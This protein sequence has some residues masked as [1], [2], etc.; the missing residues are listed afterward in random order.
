MSERKMLKPVKLEYK[1]PSGDFWDI[2]SKE[3]LSGKWQHYCEIYDELLAAFR[4]RPIRLLEIGVFKGGSMRLW[5]RYLHEDSVVVGIDA[6][7]NLQIE[8]EDGMFFREGDQ[9][10]HEFL[11]KVLEEFGPFD[12][13]VDDGSHVSSDQTDS[14]IK[15]FCDGL[16][17]DGLYIVED[18][19]TSYWESYVQRRRS[20]I[21]TAVQLLHLVHAVYFNSPH[22]SM[23]TKDA[24]DRKPVEYYE[25]WI[26]SIQFFDSMV[27]FKKR[28][29]GYQVADLEVYCD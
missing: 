16:V 26:H 1:Q 4:D 11:G 12:V 13:I 2:Y 14:F 7:D 3:P 27:A 10:D 8:L 6:V 5:K 23:F 20:F 24:E 21:D 22:A 15:L 28:L 29:R 17:E 18:T 9:A 25:A 19:H